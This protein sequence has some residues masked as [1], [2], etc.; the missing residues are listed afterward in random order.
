MSST[1]PWRLCD[2]Q[3][4][5]DAALIYHLLT[6]PQGDGGHV[7]PAVTPLPADPCPTPQAPSALPPAGP[8]LPIRIRKHRNETPER[9]PAK[10]RTGTLVY[11]AYLG[12]TEVGQWANECGTAFGAEYLPISY[13]QW[14][15]IVFKAKGGKHV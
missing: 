11:V 6:V 4:E 3:A 14:R 15:A 10:G 2:Y 12:N 8:Q 1:C 9:P 13:K 7:L 5:D